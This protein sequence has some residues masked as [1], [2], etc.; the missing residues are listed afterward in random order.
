MRLWRTSEEEKTI[1]IEYNV[2]PFRLDWSDCNLTT[3]VD[4]TFSDV[5]DTLATL[6]VAIALISISIRAGAHEGQRHEGASNGGYMLYIGCLQET[7]K[8]GTPNPCAVLLYIV[9]RC[10]MLTSAIIII[11]FP[12]LDIFLVY[13]AAY[14]MVL[15]LPIIIIIMHS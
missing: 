11:A 3:L 9:R 2:S 6:S 13:F 4:Y 5:G 15:V 8:Y 10:A 12:Y 14:S 7:S 1:N